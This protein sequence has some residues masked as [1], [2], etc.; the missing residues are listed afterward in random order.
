VTLSVR[1]SGPTLELMTGLLG[2]HVVDEAENRTRAR[3]LREELLR[4]GLLVTDTRDRRYFQSIYSREPGGVLFEVAAIQPGFTADED[5]ASLGQG[6]KLPPWEE[7]YRPLIES[8][9]PAIEYR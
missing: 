3:R 9:L 5:L 2:Y 1:S 7:R 6:L 4:M 8:R